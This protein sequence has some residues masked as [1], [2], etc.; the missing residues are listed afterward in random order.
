MLVDNNIKIYS[1]LFKMNDL[2][3]TNINVDDINL[4]MGNSEYIAYYFLI[5]IIIW[6]LP[7]F[8]FRGI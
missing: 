1:V 5:K 2:N 6:L 3:N 4:L 7:F 8:I